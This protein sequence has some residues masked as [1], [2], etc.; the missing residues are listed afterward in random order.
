MVYYANTNWLDACGPL[1]TVPQCPLLGLLL[2]SQMLSETQHKRFS[3]WR[4]GFYEVRERG[5]GESQ[6]LSLSALL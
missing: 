6:F 5:W 3:H 2:S 4:E 1:E